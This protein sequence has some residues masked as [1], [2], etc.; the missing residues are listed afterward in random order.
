MT[1]QPDQD[2]MTLRDQ[3]AMAA[4]DG[5]INL[6]YNQIM[7]NESGSI[8]FVEIATNAYQLADALMN[9]RMK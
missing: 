8:S 1:T 7:T 6:E 2:Q 5:L 4:L 3:F 9:A